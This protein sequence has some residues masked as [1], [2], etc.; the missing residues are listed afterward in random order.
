MKTQATGYLGFT[1]K[2]APNEKEQTLFRQ[3][4]KKGLTIE[5]AKLKAVWDDQRI[6]SITSAMTNMTI[7]Q[8]N[9]AAA[10]NGIKLS[11]HDKKLLDHYARQTASNYCTGCASI[12]ES[13]INYKVSISDVMRYLMYCRGYGEPERA[14]SAFRRIP[15]KTREI[16][17]SLD[18]KEAER[19]CPQSIQIG[20]LMREACSELV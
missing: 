4:A 14:K 8:A 1:E 20:Q 2:I 13:S 12:C 15:S 9:V 18:Y 7:L 11:L 10:V 6:A 19:Q 5:Q 16:M 3:L 17:A